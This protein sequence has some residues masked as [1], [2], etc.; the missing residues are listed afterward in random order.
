[1]T[2]TAARARES[3]YRIQNNASTADVTLY[4]EIGMFGVTASEFTQDLRRVTANTIEL[5]IS[6]P[7]GEVF[8]AIAI[9]NALKSHRARVNVTVD[10]IAASSASFIAMAGDSIKM[11][12]NAQMMIHAAHA[13]CVGN[14]D[15]MVK[16]AA[17]LEKCSDNIADIYAQ[18]AGGSVKDWRNRMAAETWF[19]ADEAVSVGLADEVLSGSRAS[20]AVLNTAQWDLSL[21]RYPGRSKAPN[22]LRTVPAARSRRATG[23]ASGINLPELRRAVEE[24]LTLA[25]IESTVVAALKGL[26]GAGR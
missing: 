13:I 22:P 20:T 18:R 2:I 9:Y 3:W 4:D 5:H 24:G 7:G 8:D 25:R 17:L 15:D 16:C 6:S 23:S 12:R 14:A 21:F 19:S 1:M 26:E 10:G 11:A